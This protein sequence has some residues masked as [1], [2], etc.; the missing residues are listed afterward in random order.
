[1]DWPSVVQVDRNAVNERIDEQSQNHE[2]R[3]TDAGARSM[4]AT[5]KDECYAT[6]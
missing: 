3:D 2:R 5:G 1:M 4:Q 6:D